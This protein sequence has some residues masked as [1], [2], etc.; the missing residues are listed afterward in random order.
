AANRNYRISKLIVYPRIF[1]EETSEG[2]VERTR[3]DLFGLRLGGY[4]DRRRPNCHRIYAYQVINPARYSEMVETIQAARE[5]EDEIFEALKIDE[6]VVAKIKTLLTSES[7]IA[8]NLD[9]EHA[10]I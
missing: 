2:S 10:A 7:Q 6:E 1:K 3:A 9:T 8:G 4:E 5:S